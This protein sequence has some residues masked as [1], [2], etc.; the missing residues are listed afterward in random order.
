MVVTSDGRGTISEGPGTIGTKIIDN[1]YPVEEGLEAGS[2][3]QTRDPILRE[4]EGV[5]K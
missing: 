4:E 3:K 5:S 1:R 2:T